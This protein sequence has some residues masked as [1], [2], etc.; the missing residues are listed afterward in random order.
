MTTT[1][2]LIS[3]IL[4][5][6]II[7]STRFF[8]FIVFG[9]GKQPPKVIMYLGKYLPPAIITAITIYCFKDIKFYELPFGIREIISSLTVV[10]LHI[11]FKNT[12]VSISVGTILYMTLLRIF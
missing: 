6:V 4:M 10:L 1:K 12:M 9:N 2:L 3:I 7:A 11:K 5:S 8:P